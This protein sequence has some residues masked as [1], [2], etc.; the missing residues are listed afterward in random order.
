MF[1]EDHLDYVGRSV[2]RPVHLTPPLGKLLV[3]GV[4]ATR[5]IPKIPAEI[6]RRLAV[7]RAMNQSDMELGLGLPDLALDRVAGLD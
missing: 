1:R 6:P 7:P 3:Q 5:L 2:A 4:Q